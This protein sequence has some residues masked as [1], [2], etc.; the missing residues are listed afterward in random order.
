MTILKHLPN[1]DEKLKKC[2]SGFVYWR[3]TRFVYEF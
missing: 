2:Y 1:V 3:L